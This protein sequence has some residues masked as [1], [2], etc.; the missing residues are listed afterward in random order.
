MEK[1][2]KHKHPLVRW[3]IGILV[4]QREL[5]ISRRLAGLTGIPWGYTRKSVYGL[6][7]NYMDGVTL[8]SNDLDHA[9]PVSYFIAC[10]ELLGAMHEKGIAHLDLRRGSNWLIQPDG[11]P[12]IIDFQSGFLV[13]LFPGWLKHIL[14]SI[15]YSGLYKMWDQKC[16]QGLDS[17]RKKIFYRINRFRR[18]WIFSFF[19]SS[20]G[21]A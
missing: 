11:S 14:F 5:F 15:D 13:H 1:T 7:Y 9:L 2:F 4:T 21:R 6:T 16:E 3:T 19:L 10:E 17:N 12:G 18:L 20:F 8:G